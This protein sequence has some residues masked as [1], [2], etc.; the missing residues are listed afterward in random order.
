MLSRTDLA[1]STI[2]GKI[3][4]AANT[5]AAARHTPDIGIFI[6]WYYENVPPRDLSA[7]KPAVL[8]AAA[9]AHRSLAAK[10]TPGTALVRVYN[11]RQQSAGWHSDYTVLETVNDDMP[12]LVDSLTAALNNAGLTVHLVIHPVFNA[13]RDS[14]GNLNGF[15]DGPGPGAVA[16]SFVRIEFSHV[17]DDSLMGIQK[18]IHDVLDDVRA[19]V[20][21]WGGMRTRM[22]D[23]IDALRTDIPGVSREELDEARAFLQWAHDDQFTFLGCRELDLVRRGGKAELLPSSRSRLGVLRRS[24]RLV[25]L[26]KEGSKTPNNM[27]TLVRAFLHE[28]D[29]VFIAKANIKATV[30]RPVHMDVIGIKRFNAKGEPVGQSLFVGLFTASAYNRSPRDM[31]LLRRKLHNTLA[32]SEFPATSHDGKALLNIL[33]TFPRDELF[34]ISED[35]LYQTAMGILHLQERQRVAVFVR[36][37]SFERFMSVLIYIPRD[38]YMY[39]LRQRMRVIL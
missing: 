24:N 17:P 14:S 32:R 15:S 5:G 39:M 34:Q 13:Q 6:R 29:L 28:P 37:D 10:R 1:R 38:R 18:N 23:M 30:H 11:P 20:E 9:M 19:A 12:F 22:R 35:H 2:L 27:P 33:E 4:V 21:D 16:E 26:E 7:A 3:V 36:R 31:P 8:V 25:F